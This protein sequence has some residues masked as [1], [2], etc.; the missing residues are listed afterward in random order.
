ML[1]MMVRNASLLVGGDGSRAGARIRELSRSATPPHILARI[2]HLRDEAVS[3]ATRS[4][5]RIMAARAPNVRAGRNLRLEK[6]R[7]LG[8]KYHCQALV[9]VDTN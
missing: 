6:P 9:I 7:A 3:S 2:R 1:D 4:G 8:M 5:S